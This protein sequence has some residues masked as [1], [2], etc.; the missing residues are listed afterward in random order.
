MNTKFLSFSTKTLL[1]AGLALSLIG[2]TK[3]QMQSNSD[4]TNSASAMPTVDH[5]KYLVN[6]IGCGD[7]HTPWT[8]TPQGPMPDS[9][10]LLSG[11]PASFPIQ[12]PAALAP[13]WMAA[14]SMTMTAWSGPW[15][16]SFTANLTPDSATGLG[17]WTQDQFVSAIR[18]GKHQG[19]GRAILP[20]M[21]WNWLR[22]LTDA[23]L[24]SIYLYLRS[25]PA[26]SNKVPDPLPPSMPVGMPGANGIPPKPGS[27]GMATPIPQGSM[28]PPPHKK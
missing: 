20:P 4:S 27:E 21:P 22:N 17:A 14:G 18:N 19:T 25:I 7:C 9:T 24:Q 1:A 28:P 10:K 26:I 11:H 2:C 8:M 15:G 16:V 12:A 23:D 13:P 6:T 3:S 5:G